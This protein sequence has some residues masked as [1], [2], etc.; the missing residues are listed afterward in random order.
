MQLCFRF[1]S[2]FS[3]PPR[4]PPPVMCRGAAPW[5]DC[6]VRLSGTAMPMVVAGGAGSP[7]MEFWG[8]GRKDNQLGA[9]VKGS[10]R[11]KLKK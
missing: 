10:R 2:V 8:R 4:P 6:S 1:I 5:R 11:I 9:L 7:K 3:L